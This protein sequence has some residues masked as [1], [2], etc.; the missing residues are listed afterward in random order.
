MLRYRVLVT[1]PS[2]LVLV[3]EDD[4]DI[5]E[6]LTALVEDCGLSVCAA[7][8]GVEGLARLRAGPR[9]D[10][11]FLDR[12]LPKLDGAALLAT[13]KSDPTLAAIPVVWMSADPGCPEAAEMHLEKPF[14]VTALLEILGS[15]R[16][17]KPVLN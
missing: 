7:R 13:L 15:I 16:D 1:A 2:A 10:A 9:P 5:R 6:A 12:W 11:V 17:R 4:A 14:D 3:V 8:D